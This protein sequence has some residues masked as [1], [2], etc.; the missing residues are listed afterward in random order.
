MH[1]MKAKVTNIFHAEFANEKLCQHLDLNLQPSNPV[2]LH[3]SY[4][5]RTWVSLAVRLGPC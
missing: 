2:I 5:F 3:G 1:T 4:I